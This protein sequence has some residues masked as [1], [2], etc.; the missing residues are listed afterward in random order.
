MGGI[1]AMSPRTYNQTRRYIIGVLFHQTASCDMRYPTEVHRK[2]FSARRKWMSAHLTGARRCNRRNIP[3]MFGQARSLVRR[4]CLSQGEDWNSSAKR[5]GQ[6]AAAQDED[7]APSGENATTACTRTVRKVLACVC[8]SAWRKTRA[9]SCYYTR[10]LL[11][12]CALRRRMRR[13]PVLQKRREA[14][15]PDTSF[16]LD[17]DGP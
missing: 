2:N 4:N 14:K 17:G 16:D 5:L 12:E 7:R 10:A 6:A 11:R 13:R 15:R 9:R 1:F 8:A 3:V